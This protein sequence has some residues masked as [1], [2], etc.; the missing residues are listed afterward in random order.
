MLKLFLGYL[1]PAEDN[2]RKITRADKDFAKKHDFEDIKFQSK[3]ETFTKLQKNFFINISIFR[4][5]NKENI[6]S[7][8]Q[9]NA[10]KK[11]MLIY[12]W[13]EKKVKCTMFLLWILIHLCIII[14]Y[15]VEDNTFDVIV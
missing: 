6:Q 13:K 8:C 12:Y 15:I 4:Y 14:H 5:E 1:H 11:H 9:K 7:M 3:L 10:L 2:L